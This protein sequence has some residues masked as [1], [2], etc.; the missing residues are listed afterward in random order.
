M[1]LAV[2]LGLG[3]A[4]CAGGPPASP[5]ETVPPSAV[6]SP[7]PTRSPDGVR[8]TGVLV[9]GNVPKLGKLGTWVLDGTG[10]DSPWLPW[11]ASDA[12]SIAQGVSV[13]IRLADGS[14]IGWWF[15]DLADA[16]D[17]SGENARR[18]GGREVDA[19]PLDS[20]S[21]EPLPAGALGPRGQA[22]PRRRPRRRRDVLE[23]ARA[24]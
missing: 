14:P 4:G 20:V 5:G 6:S 21:L 2:A 8:V 3:M 16:S 23:R 19:P 12:I 11:I 15:A 13:T 1:T 22:L 9:A 17:G 24:R 10:S 18:L 7:A